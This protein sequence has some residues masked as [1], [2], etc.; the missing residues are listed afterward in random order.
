MRT[1]QRLA[2]G[3][4]KE[5]AAQAPA[6]APRRPPAVTLPTRSFPGSQPLAGVGLATTLSCLLFLPR[7]G[8]PGEFGRRSKA[9][10]SVWSGGGRV[11]AL[12]GSPWAAASLSCSSTVGPLVSSNSSNWSSRNK[13]G[14][15]KS[16]PS[17]AGQW[18]GSGCSS[19]VLCEATS[20]LMIILLIVVN[21]GHICG[22]P[23]LCIYLLMG[24]LVLHCCVQGFL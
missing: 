5:D 20:V 2:E 9:M 6:E 17:C 3:A 1:V 11:S 10:S 21:S 22:A 15:R 7:G 12:L 24:P 4:G 23:Y 13:N 19:G 16:G 14:S 18:S 8:R